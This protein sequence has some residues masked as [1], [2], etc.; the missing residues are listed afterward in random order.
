MPPAVSRLESFTAFVDD[1][2]PRL[3]HALAGAFGPDV[4]HESVADA[5]AYGWEHWDRIAV[6]E[7]PAGYLYRVAMRAAPRIARRLPDLPSPPPDE[8]PWVEPGLAKA[9]GQLSER[10]RI[11]VVLVRGHGYTFREAADLMGGIGISTVEKH[12]ERGMS[13]LR[14]ALEVR[15]DV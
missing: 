11:A 2:E 10:Q 13:K 9:L 4:G 15:I 12:V 5:L 1:V 6:M 7:N 3:R 8:M 14:K